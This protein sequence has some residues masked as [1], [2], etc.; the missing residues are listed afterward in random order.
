MTNKTDME[1]AFY[2]SLHKEY[3]MMKEYSEHRK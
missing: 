3:E 1:K 2:H